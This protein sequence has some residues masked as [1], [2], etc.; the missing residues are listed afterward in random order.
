[1]HQNDQSA[2][3]DVSRITALIERASAAEFSHVRTSIPLIP[4]HEKVAPATYMSS[5]KRHVF[6]QENRIT[7]DKIVPTVIINSISANANAF[8]SAILSEMRTGHLSLPHLTIKTGGIGEIASDI[9]SLEL[10]HRTFD[11]FVNKSLLDGKRFRDHEIGRY[12]TSVSAANATPLFQYDPMALLLGVWG[13]GFGLSR[14]RFARLL[15]GEIVAYDVMPGVRTN[16][17]SDVFDI[18]KTT[19][20]FISDQDV[21][22]DFRLEPSGEFKTRKNPSDLT[23]GSIAPS[24]DLTGGITARNYRHNIGFM[25]G[26][27]RGY[28]FPVGSVSTTAQN[29]A[30]RRVLIALGL[31]AIVSCA[32][33]GYALRSGCAF[34]IQSTREP[35]GKPH[36]LAIEFLGN[37]TRNNVVIHL[38]LT[39]ELLAALR[40][41]VRQAVK[42]A[43]LM[44]LPWNTPGLV[45]E[46]DKELRAILA[47][48]AREKRASRKRDRVVQT[49]F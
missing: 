28:Q 9:T 18:P 30:A 12:L 23:L 17:K 45:L 26:P 16:S 2:E 33:Q 24:V 48:T 46:P 32:Q 3:H 1:M 49:A 5:D 27:M 19:P 29:D 41:G 11:Q 35:N 15:Q 4:L 43:L 7:D 42:A 40:D 38:D 14:L 22:N 8:E 21:T 44:G 10:A 34:Q 20:I 47:T 13:Q 6:A 39:N 37:S 25:L 36:D 31:L